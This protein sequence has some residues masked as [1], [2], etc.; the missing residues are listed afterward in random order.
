MN[1]EAKT[2]EIVSGVPLVLEQLERAQVDI[3]VTTAKRYPRSVTKFHQDA[4]TLACQDAETAQ[5]CFYRLKRSGKFL[6]GPSVRMAE[7]VQYCWGNIQAAAR[8]IDIGEQ[9]LT[10]QGVCFDCEKNIRQSI[11]VKRRIVTKDGRRFNADMIQTT[12]NAAISLAL[13]NAIFRVVPRALIQPIIEKAK[14]TSLGKGKTIEQQRDSAVKWYTERGVD[15][16]QLMAALGKTGREDLGVDDL[17]NLRGMASAIKDG[18]TTMEEALSVNGKPLPEPGAKI[19]RSEALD[20]LTP[21]KDDSIAED[22]RDALTA[23][24]NEIMKLLKQAKG[25]VAVDKIL[26]VKKADVDAIKAEL[27]DVAEIIE[28]L[29]D[30]QRDA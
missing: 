25:K 23:K 27:P 11:E 7:I 21:L 10:A 22:P 14:A 15:E 19:R 12:S 24:G 3:Q 6:E 29:A 2:G 16:K 13:R 5:Q 17:I 4:E 1:E 28:A 18:E 30:E 9:E 20:D 26:K 8:I